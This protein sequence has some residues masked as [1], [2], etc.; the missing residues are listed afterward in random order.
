VY[1]LEAPILPRQGEPNFES[2]ALNLV[3][4]CLFPYFRVLTN[5]IGVREN[6]DYAEAESYGSLP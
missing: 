4:Y 2:Q 3:S 6:A 1:S 5:N